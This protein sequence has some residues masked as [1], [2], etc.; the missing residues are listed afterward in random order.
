[1]LLGLACDYYYHLSQVL[2]LLRKEAGTGII[3]IIHIY[4]YYFQIQSMIYS[5]L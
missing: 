4:K 3:D 5:A 1:M 2:Y